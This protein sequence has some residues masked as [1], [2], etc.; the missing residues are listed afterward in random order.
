MENKLD[1]IENPA[2]HPKV[3]NLLLETFQL[4]LPPAIQ[5]PDTS[6]SPELEAKPRR[7]IRRKERKREEKVMTKHNMEEQ[8]EVTRD[9]ADAG[10]SLDRVEG[11]DQDE[12]SLYIDV[13]LPPEGT[14][15]ALTS[16]RG[17][18]AAQA[19]LLERPPSS[20]PGFIRVRSGPPLGRRPASS[21]PVALHQEYRKHWARA[22]IPGERRSDFFWIALVEKSI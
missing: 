21:D 16:S 13:D 2:R 11:Q 6:T 18:T 14:T 22:N 5:V 12:S 9:T 4:V 1:D 20:G 15:S 19:S 3:R 17:R 7:R 8:M 10:A